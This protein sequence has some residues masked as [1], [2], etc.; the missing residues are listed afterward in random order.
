VPAP[1]P[2]PAPDWAT[3]PPE[4]VRPDWLAAQPLTPSAPDSAPDWLVSTPPAAAE[5][6]PAPVEPA[7]PAAPLAPADPE[8]PAEAVSPSTPASMSPPAW[9]FESEALLPPG[10]GTNGDGHPGTGPGDGAGDALPAS[11]VTELSDGLV[12]RVP[13]AH[14]APPLRR[15][16]TTEPLAAHTPTAPR[17]RDQVRS[18]LSNFQASQRAGRAATDPPPPDRSPQENR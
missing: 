4:A 16:T 8:V 11:A 17:D 7:E 6:P 14:L 12:R 3:G 9:W 1:A 5:P 15:D 2:P 13:G 18:M 10:D